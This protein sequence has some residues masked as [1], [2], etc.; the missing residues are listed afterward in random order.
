MIIAIHN[1]K[2]GIGKTTITAHL[3]FRL[4]QLGIK[5]LVITLDRQGDVIRYFTPMVTRSSTRTSRCGYGTSPRSTLRG[6]CRRR[7]PCEASR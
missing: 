1:H 2:G 6:R 7:T 3:A 4:D 5:C